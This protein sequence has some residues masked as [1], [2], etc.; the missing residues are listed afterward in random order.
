MKTRVS[1]STTTNWNVDVLL[2]SLQG[3]IRYYRRHF[4]QL[5][6]QLRVTQNRLSKNRSTSGSCSTNC[7][8]GASRICT[9][10]EQQTK[11][12]K[13][14]KV[15]RWTRPCGRGSARTLGRN[16]AAG[17]S[18]TSREKYSV[19]AAWGLGSSGTWPCSTAR[20]HSP[21]LAIVCLRGAVWCVYPAR[22]WAIDCC[23]CRQAARSRR[24]L[25]RRAAPVTGCQLRSI[26][27]HR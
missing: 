12:T 8:T 19:P 10:G 17:T 16:P 5:F 15:C 21:A 22:A 2:R 26:S 11:S 6:C 25:R 4:H 7:G 3:R 23:S 27:Q 1:P 24:P 9:I 18:S 14:F 13:C 20:S